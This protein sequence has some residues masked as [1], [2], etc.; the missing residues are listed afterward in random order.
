[1]RGKI[2]SQ[3][4]IGT[5]E[6]LLSIVTIKGWIKPLI[7]VMSALIFMSACATTKPCI[8][9]PAEVIIQKVPVP[10]PCPPPPEIP[11]PTLQIVSLSSNLTP[12]PD[13]LLALVHDYVELQRVEA[14]LRQI[15]ETYKPK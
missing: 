6:P 11:A 9:P 12:W 15:L 14:E 7:I 8:C 1:M 3:L 4:I 10:I 13:I 2:A 5:G